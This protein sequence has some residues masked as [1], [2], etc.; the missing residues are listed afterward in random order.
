VSLIVVTYRSRD[1]I[2]ACLR[3]AR[4][5]ATLADMGLEVVIVDNDPGDGSLKAALESAPDALVIGNATNVGFGRACNQAFAL[6]SG[7][8]WLLLNPD[9]TMSS[10][11]LAKLVAYAESH[12]TAAAVAPTLTGAGLDRAESA[13][14]LPGIRSALGHFLLLNRIL[15]RGDTGPWRGLQLSRRPDLGAR[16]V[17]WA[18]AGALLLRPEA[19]RAVGGFDESYFLY[20][21][22]VD[23]GRRL[24]RTGWET[25]LLPDA[26]V[27]HTVAAS[28]GGISDRWIVALHDEYARHTNRVSLALFDLIAAVGL[29]LRSLRAGSDRQH[30]ERMS[31][32]A[33]SAFSLAAHTLFP[34][35]AGD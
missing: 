32:A 35:R 27:E 26:T 22:D 25:W 13:G 19:V 31:V 14:M 17:E 12:P 9:A 30:R 24:G 29:A 2:G 15:G 18:S 4:R 21:E 8:W 10:D 11:A 34:G 5:A 3:S 6:A 1:V 16:R 23:L 28:S 33:R 7:R 20:A